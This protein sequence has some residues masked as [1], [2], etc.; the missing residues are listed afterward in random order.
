MKT[1]AVV[2]TKE[3]KVEYLE[4]TTPQMGENDV[5]VETEYS[6]ISNGTE[7]SFLRGDRTDGIQPWTPGMKKPFPLVPGYQK[8]GRIIDKG[9]RVKH[10]SIGQQVFVTK[11]KVVGM[12][13]DFAG[14]I[15]LG[16]AEAD[17]VIA[18]PDGHSTEIYSGL[19][20]AQVGYNAGIRGDAEGGA[21][22]AVI[23]DGMVGL[24][25]AQTLQARGFKVALVGRYDFRLNLFQTAQHDIRIH[26][27]KDENWLKTL[28]HWADGELSIVVDSVG[29]DVNAQ[30]NE[31]LLGMLSWGG[32]FVAAGHHGNHANIDMKLLTRSEITLHCPCG[33]T[34]QRLNLTMEWI[35]QGK[36]DT[37]SLITHRFPAEQADQAWKQ[38]TEQRDSTLGVILKW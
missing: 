36:L 13:L 4:V 7:A 3:N 35:R 17:D 28:Q 18:L 15:A 26:S 23:G 1:S 14:H 6:W 11:T 5:L 37:A 34:N 2:F 22:V 12:H 32:H 33:W 27:R 21:C 10:L 9:V 31:K 38:I 29:N 8:T 16:P 30:V 20:L 19:V 24:W 25:A